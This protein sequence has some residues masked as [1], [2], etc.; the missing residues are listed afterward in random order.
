MEHKNSLSDFL[1]KHAVEYVK[2]IIESLKLKMFDRVSDFIS[3]ILSKLIALIFISMFILMLN[4]GIALW[5]GELLGKTAY[6]FFVVAGFYG[7]TGIISY[8]LFK[9]RF[10]MVVLNYFLRKFS[11]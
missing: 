2:T 7:L 1:I 3:S 11:K 4:I 8:F 10:K 6:G 5:L 9:R